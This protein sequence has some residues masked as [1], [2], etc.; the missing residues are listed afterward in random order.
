MWNRYQGITIPIYKGGGKDSLNVNSYRGITLN[1][2]ISKVLETL[3]LNRLEPLFME[4]GLPHRNQSAYR[5]SVSCADAIFA[6]QEVLNRY[7]MDGGK[8]Y[9]CLYDLENAFDSVEFSVLLRRLFDV[10]VNSNKWRILRSWYTDSQSSV[11]LGQHVSSPFTL[12]CW[13]RQGSILS[14]AL[15][16]LVKDP[17]LRQLQSLS[18]GASVNNM[19]AGGFLHADD[20]H[21]L[22]STKT[23]L[24]AQISTVKRF[25]EGNFLKMNASKCE[26]EVVYKSRGRNR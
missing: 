8:V 11:C 14:P 2:V 9:M 25:T 5:K 17:L 15:F 22:A 16:L 6:T 3:I 13:V 7:L 12:G 24:E 1:S 10:G 18:I 26:I 20:I 21:R 23:T 4:A 19:Y